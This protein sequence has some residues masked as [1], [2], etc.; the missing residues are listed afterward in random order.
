QKAMAKKEDEKNIMEIAEKKVI[1]IYPD[2]SLMVAFHKLDRF[3]ISRIPVVSRIN[4]KRMIG[5]ITAEN[6][7]SR[8]GYHIQE[9]DH[10]NEN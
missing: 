5:I 8:F 6:I 4:D 7:V 3:H 2:Q 9:G 1:S 10:E